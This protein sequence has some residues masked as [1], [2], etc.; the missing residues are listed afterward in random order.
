V[1]VVQ[2]IFPFEGDTRP[3]EMAKMKGRDAHLEISRAYNLPVGDAIRLVTERIRSG[4]VSTRQVWPIDGAHPGDEGYA[5]FAEAAW[6]GYRDGVAHQVVCRAPV[7]MLHAP[8]YM[9]SARVRI[10]RLG[11]LPAGWRQG[12]PNRVSAWY[13]GLMSRW[14]DDEAIAE[15]GPG[16]TPPAPLRVQFRGTMVLLY[17]EETLNSGKYSVAI[18][19]QTIKRPGTRGTDAGFFDASSVLMGGNRQHAQLL[20]TGL[21]AGV[22]HSLEITP[23]FSPESTR[24]LRLE[25]ICVA[26]P[27]A[28]VFR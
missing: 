20:A 1:P 28:A 9:T 2:V 24:E 26:G 6:T 3:G 7:K 4:A 21:Q 17:G 10:S 13:D 15:S 5:L 23:Q 12:I 14:L 16:K 11:A 18:D 25:S 22:E 19:G 27:G 8:T